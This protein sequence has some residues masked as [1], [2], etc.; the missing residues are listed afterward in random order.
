V[1]RAAVPGSIES[2]AVL[3]AGA[4]DRLL[5]VECVR[6]AYA[7]GRF[8]AEIKRQFELIGRDDR[9][10]ADEQRLPL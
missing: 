10:A 3:A 4:T 2:I 7:L 5:I 8:D 9:R 1:S 6:T